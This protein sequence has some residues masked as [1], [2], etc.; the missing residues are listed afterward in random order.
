MSQKRHCCRNNGYQ[1]NTSRNVDG[2]SE[3]NTNDTIFVQFVKSAYP[4]FS[5]TTKGIKLKH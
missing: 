4:Q 2:N 1:F 3:L 5:G